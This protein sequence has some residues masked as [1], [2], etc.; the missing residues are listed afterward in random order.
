[1]TYTKDMK[2]MMRWLEPADSLLDSEEPVFEVRT[3]LVVGQVW[4]HDEPGRGPYAVADIRRRHFKEDGT[5]HYQA[6]FYQED[7][8]SMLQVSEAVRC[9]MERFFPKR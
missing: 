7:M 4:F 6:A 9:F 1:M 5:Y 8:V 3:G 2:D